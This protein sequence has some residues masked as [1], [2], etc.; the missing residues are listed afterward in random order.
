MNKIKIKTGEK[1]G[2]LT[3][4]DEGER[5]ILPSGQTNRTVDCICECGNKTNVRL[6]HLVRNRI[7]SCGCITKT[8]KGLS[9]TPIY[10]I[11]K[12]MHERC[13]GKTKNANIYKGRGITV[14]KDWT[15]NFIFFYNWA[16]ENGY[17]KGLQIDRKNNNKGYSPENC[18]FVTPKINVNNRECTF[19][20]NYKGKKQSLQL[21]MQKL[22]YPN[23]VSTVRSRI[24]R[25]WDVEN[26]IFKNPATNY[27]AR[28]EV[29]I[30][31]KKL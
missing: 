28:K 19:F 24:L 5:L 18:R 2:R 12:A 29:Q 10:K 14:C 13:D 27:S 30:L 23:K 26:A 6:L 31:K 25:G 9:K 1:F 15:D 20:V 16:K 4:F 11:W 17:N 7:S 3:V 8:R 22:N 21:L